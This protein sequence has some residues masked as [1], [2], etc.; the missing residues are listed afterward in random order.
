MVDTSAVPRTTVSKASSDDVQD[1][2]VETISSLSDSMADKS[3]SNGQ[4]DGSVG[5]DNIDR[6]SNEHANGPQI[7]DDIGGVPVEVDHVSAPKKKKR[8]PS[9]PKSKRGQ[10]TYGLFSRGSFHSSDVTQNAPTGFEEFHAEVLTPEQAAED[11]SLYSNDLPFINRVLTAVQRFE[12]TRRLSPERRHVFY[13]YLAYGGIDVGPNMFQGAAGLSTEQKENMDKT[14]LAAAMSQ[15]SIDND[16]HD[17]T[18]DDRI[19]D[20]DFE[21]CMKSFLSR[22]AVR[23]RGFETREAVEN[24]TTTLERFMDYLLQHE[25]CP[26]YKIEIL[27][28][29]DLCREA[30]LDLWH[31]AEANRWLPGNFNVACSTLLDGE[32]SRNFDGSTSWAPEDTG[33]ADFIGFTPDLASQIIKFGIAGAAPEEV[34]Q[35][36]VSIINDTTQTQSI[37]VTSAHSNTGLE[38]TQI[39]PASKACVQ[40]YRKQSHNLRPVGHIKAIPWTNPEQAPEDTSPN[41][42]PNTSPSLAPLKPATTAPQYTIILEAPILSLL[43]IGTKLICTIHHLNIGISYIDAIETCFPSWH[44]Y[45]EGNE[46]M[47]GYKKGRWVEGSVPYALERENEKREEAEREEEEEEEEAAEEEEQKLLSSDM[48]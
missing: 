21:G 41:T 4:A 1:P 34:Y 24:V 36:Y 37:Q 45:A 23:I 25:V 30:A 12:R 44:D 43:H 38:I 2:N 9:K 16:K 18:S 19:Y 8:K 39:E 33:R 17:L 29:R 7:T 27:S 35:K 48:A 22:R 11:T 42:S 47:M 46:L 5:T 32:A 26:E 10:V 20:V 40:M 13:D 28:T 15:L 6:Q 31:C 14:E 3:S